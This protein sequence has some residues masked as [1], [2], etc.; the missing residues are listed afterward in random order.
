MANVLEDGAHSF[1]GRLLPEQQVLYLRQWP[2]FS[3]GIDEMIPGASVPVQHSWCFDM[4]SS[5]RP[6]SFTLEGIVSIAAS[7][8]LE[9]E[10]LS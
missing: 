7:V 1:L 8:W 3:S 6:A 4:L 2:T 5:V 9:L 10:Q